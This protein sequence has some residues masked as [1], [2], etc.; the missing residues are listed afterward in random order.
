MTTRTLIEAEA[1]EPLLGSRRL[2]L[3]DCRFDLAR[4]ESGRQRYLDEHLPGAMYADLNRDLSRP[5]TPTSGRHPAARARGVRGAAARM[6]RERRL[7]GGRLR[8]RQRHVRRPPV[9]DAALARPRRRSGARRRHASLDPARPADRRRGAGDRARQLRRAAATRT[10]GERRRGTARRARPGHAGPRCAGAGALPWRGRADRQGRRTRPGRA[11]LPV[12]AQ[13]RRPGPLPAARAAAHGTRGLPRQR[14]TGAHHRLLRVGRHRLPPAA[15]HGARGPRGRTPLSGLVERVVERSSAARWRPA[16]S[17][18]GPPATASFNR[19]RFCYRSR[20]FFR[21]AEPTLVETSARKPMPG[22]PWKIEDS[23]E[24]YGVNAWGNGY[25]G[26][27]AAGH[28][29][30]RPD[31]TSEHEIDLHEVIRGLA[32]ARPHHAGGGAL[33]RHPAPPP[34]APARRVRHGDRRERLPRPLCRRVPDQG[35]PAAPRGRG[36]LRL[37]RASSASASRWAPSPSCS[38]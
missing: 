1:L 38:P 22:S 27:N 25:F 16:R 14:C 33:L 23:L 21:A 18:D 15:R 8:R 9:V 2:R 32:R 19:G 35:Q 12:H 10:G 5:A 13:P 37:R 4:P 30:V 6:G 11:Q 34:E 31:Q 26:I 17:L 36:G 29:V 7:A 20:H 24:L 3:F 28:V